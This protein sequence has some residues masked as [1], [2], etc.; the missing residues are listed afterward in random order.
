M[1]APHCFTRF[2]SVALIALFG[3][4]YAAPNDPSFKVENGVLEVG[5]DDKPLEA[6]TPEDLAKTL[7]RVRAAIDNPNWE[8]RDAATRALLNL[9][10]RQTIKLLAARYRTSSD[11][12]A[13]RYL[14]EYGGASIIPDVIPGIYDKTHKKLD[15]TGKPFITVTSSGL[16][17]SVIERSDQFPAMTREWA[18]NLHSD[19]IVHGNF[20]L[21]QILDQEK[22]WWEN[23][24]QAI[25]TQ[26]YASATWVP[27]AK[28]D[29]SYKEKLKRNPPP[30]PTPP[31][32]TGMQTSAGSQ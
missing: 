10:D 11:Y 30:P 18:K 9:N 31:M 19:F 24:K 6:L 2:I 20:I 32:I 1:Q 23:N 21:P 5:P 15:L 12:N 22:Q 13:V 4:A 25:T 17:L 27:S 7:P 26:Q 29:L 14:R 28:L 16:L 3:V 8:I